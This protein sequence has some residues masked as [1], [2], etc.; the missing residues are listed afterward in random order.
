MQGLTPLGFPP[1]LWQQIRKAD[2]FRT[3]A[4]RGSARCLIG[5]VDHPAERG[6]GERQAENDKT[7]RSIRDDTAANL[8]FQTVGHCMFRLKLICVVDAG[9]TRVCHAKA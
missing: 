8:R 1:A 4:I 6:T 2:P 9:L 7:R 5:G 3:E